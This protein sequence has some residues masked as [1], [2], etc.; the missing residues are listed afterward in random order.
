VNATETRRRELDRIPAV[1]QPDTAV[2][3][4]IPPWWGKIIKCNSTTGRGT[5]KRAHG[6]LPGLT[7]VSGAVEVEV[8]IGKESFIRIDDDV[9]C[10]WNGSDVTPSWT[11]WLPL[12]GIHWEEPTAEELADEQDDPDESTDCDDEIP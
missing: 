5:V 7:V 8:Y 11:A 4:S 1:V 2:P 6:S 10:T 9:Y 3:V 12:R